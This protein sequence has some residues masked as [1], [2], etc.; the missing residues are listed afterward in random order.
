MPMKTTRKVEDEID[1]DDGPVLATDRLRLATLPSQ[2]HKVPPPPPPGRRARGT[3][4]LGEPVPSGLIDVRA[5]AATYAAKRPAPFPPPLPFAEGTAPLDLVEAEPPP[6]RTVRLRVRQIALAAGIAVALGG[7]AVFAASRIDRTARPESTASAAFEAP[8][9]VLR[10]DRVPAEDAPVMRV[11]PFR[12]T[13]T[14]V[15]AAE[16]AAPEPPRVRR[17][18][19]RRDVASVTGAAM[20][21]S[22]S[23]IASAVVAAHQRL[24]ACGARHAMSGAVPVTLRVAPSGEVASV[25]VGLGTTSFRD[26]VASALRRQRLPASQVGTTARF[27]IIVR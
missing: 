22:N 12:T 2:L 15:A 26:C 11:I 19:I 13:V 20:R 14:E 10:A 7:A 5:M 9:L 17:P 27:P 3:A 6:A 24:A 8:P 25:T 1:L 21:P 23:E 18:A 16:P 4:P